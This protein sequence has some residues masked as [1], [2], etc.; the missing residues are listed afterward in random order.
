MLSTKM[1]TSLSSSTGFHPIL[2]N[3]L[4]E[5]KAAESYHVGFIKC[6]EEKLFY[7]FQAQ[8]ESL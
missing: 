7:Y 4:E 5:R 2:N 6:Y 3:Q 8:N 1:A